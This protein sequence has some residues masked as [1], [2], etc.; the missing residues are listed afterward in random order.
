[1]APSCQSPSRRPALIL[2]MRP[3]HRHPDM[4]MPSPWLQESSTL[5]WVRCRFCLRS[6]PDTALLALVSDCARRALRVTIARIAG[7]ANWFR[8]RTDRTPLQRLSD[9]GGK[10]GPPCPN[11]GQRPRGGAGGERTQP[12]RYSWGYSRAFWGFWWPVRTRQK[13]CPLG[14]Y[15][16]HKSSVLTP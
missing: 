4:V 10:A 5:T 16:A 14:H 9:L 15:L 1:M 12:R 8:W 7:F 3:M 2:D 13:L 11:A 6:S